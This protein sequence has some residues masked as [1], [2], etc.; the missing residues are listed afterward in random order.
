MRRTGWTYHLEWAPATQDRLAYISRVSTTRPPAA[1]FAY[2]QL[3]GFEL[4]LDAS[5]TTAGDSGALTSFN[6]TVDGEDAGEGERLT[7]DFGAAGAYRVDL[8][9]T[10]GNGVTG[11]TSSW[12]EVA[13]GQAPTITSLRCAAA[14]EGRVRLSADIRDGDGEIARIEWCPKAD[15][16]EGEW[17]D[18]DEVGLVDEV[19]L[20]GAWGTHAR[21]AAVDDSGNRT[22]G[23]CLVEGASSSPPERIEPPREAG[24]TFREVLRSGGFGPEMVVVPAGTFRMGCLNDDG[25]CHVSTEFPV[26]EVTFDEPFAVGK[27]EVTFDDYDRFILATGGEIPTHRCSGYN[28]I[29]QCVYAL[30]FDEGWGRGSRPVIHVDAVDAVGNPGYRPGYTGWLSEQTGATYR[31]LSEAEWEYAARAGTE[32]KYS[33]GDDVGVNRANCDGCSSLWDGDRT[34]PVGSFPPNPWG[35]HDMHGNVSEWVADG[36]ERHR[37][38]YEGAPTDGSVWVPC[39]PDHYRG[40]LPGHRGGSW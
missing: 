33:W 11:G 16:G 7:H 26:R 10:D 18:S 2:R 28:I 8:A 5:A 1:R 25:D 27:Y 35:L 32:T 19:V 29:G 17:T 21:V 23:T 14:G 39:Y 30:A 20:G 37:F 4:E 31:L 22:E 12:V 34:A 6:W 38:G 9:V 24:A 3:A 36:W 40:K 13:D 15:C